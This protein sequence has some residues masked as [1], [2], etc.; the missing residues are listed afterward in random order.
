[1]GNVLYE[2]CFEFDFIYLIPII[3]IIV[4]PFF[5][6]LWQIGNEGKKT[7][8]DYKDVKAFCIGVSIF[9]VFL[10]LVTVVSQIHMYNKT[11]KAYKEGDYI[12]VEGYVEE[13]S[14]M[15]YQGH[16]DESF[17]IDGVEFSYSDFETGFGYHNAKS[18][19]GVIKGD[20]QHLKI[21][22]VEYNNKNV[23]VYIEELE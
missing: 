6:R 8:V 5:P 14:P 20:G 23:I 12:T 21:G 2:A 15:P 13:F 9:I 18:H 16:S 11:V 3:M 10:G 4:V 22:Y 17:V 7:M 1:M 19:G